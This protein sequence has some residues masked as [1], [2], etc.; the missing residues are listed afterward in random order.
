MLMLLCFLCCYRFSANKDLY[1]KKI[2]KGRNV[3]ELPTSYIRISTRNTYRIND[4][5]DT[6]QRD[7]QTDRHQTVALRSWLCTRSA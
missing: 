7:G 3:E 4:R 2:R 1:I 6:G 5:K